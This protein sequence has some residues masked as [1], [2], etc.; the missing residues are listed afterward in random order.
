MFCGDGEEGQ[1]GP[2]LQGDRPVKPREQL[3]E[4]RAGGCG[5]DG[6]GGSRNKGLR[7]ELGAWA[8]LSLEDHH[9]LS[10]EG[11]CVLARASG[12]H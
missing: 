10:R 4:P 1:G 7:A 11:R 2:P 3:E 5:Q 6:S 9:P 12:R 8:Q